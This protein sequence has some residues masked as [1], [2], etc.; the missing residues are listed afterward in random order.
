MKHVN[1]YEINFGD[2]PEELEESNP[3][4]IERIQNDNRLYDRPYAVFVYKD[5]LQDIMNEYKLDETQII[6]A[7]DKLES[8]H[9]DSDFGSFLDHNPKYMPFVKNDD[10]TI[11]KLSNIIL[12]NITEKEMSTIDDVYYSIIEKAITKVLYTNLVE[13]SEGIK[14]SNKISN[15][16]DE[17]GRNKTWVADQTGINYKTFNN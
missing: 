14:L 12:E 8:V 4:L 16:I 17:Q 7:I 2:M 3:E 13:E 9:F 11:L 15:I 10:N 6:A 5:E 1:W